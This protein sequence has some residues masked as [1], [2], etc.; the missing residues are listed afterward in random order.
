MTEFRP[1]WSDPGTDRLVQAILALENTEEVY[2]FLDDICTISEVK[3]LAQRLQVALMLNQEETYTYIA[4][5]TGASTATIS[6]V[7]RCLQY[8]AGGY[9]SVLPKI[10]Q[11]EGKNA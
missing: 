4:G 9:K 1:N 5:V 2:R 7:K 6:R 3:A 10:V 8:G 11:Q